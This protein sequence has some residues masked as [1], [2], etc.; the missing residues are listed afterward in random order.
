MR[1][2]VV[3]VVVAHNLSAEF[4]AITLQTFISIVSLHVF[5]LYKFFFFFYI[6][7]KWN[8]LLNAFCSISPSI[9]WWSSRL[10]ILFKYPT[11]F[12]FLITYLDYM[13]ISFSLKH[14]WLMTFSE[15]FFMNS[16]AKK[17]CF[18]QGKII[19]FFIFKVLHMI[20]IRI[21]EWSASNCFLYFRVSNLKLFKNIFS[22]L[23]QFTLH[24]FI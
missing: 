8:R 4:T 22:S 17:K 23:V 3:F 21:N 20:L 12:F 14:F 7:L 11:F 6:C 24:F 5:L 13:V 16:R 15:I 9:N 10:A 2:V 1:V 19:F 18:L